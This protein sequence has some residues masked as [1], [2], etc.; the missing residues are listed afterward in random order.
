MPINYD[1]SV[2]GVNTPQ[3]ITGV[4]VDRPAAT[5]VAE[6]TI[7]ISTDTQEIY[8]AQ[9]GNWILISSIT[10]SAVGTLAQTLAAGN[11][12]NNQ[13]IYLN[14]IAETNY[15]FFDFINDVYRFYLESYG[16]NKGLR[17]VHQTD[18]NLSQETRTYTYDN[19]TF[20]DII[21]T[22]QNVDST[23]ASFSTAVTYPNTNINNTLYSSSNESR[24]SATYNQGTQAA[25]SNIQS[26]V[27]STRFESRFINDIINGEFSDLLINNTNQDISILTAYNLTNL[28]QYLIKLYNTETKN[29]TITHQFEL[30]VNQGVL[31]CV[32]EPIR[33]NNVNLSIGNFDADKY[34]IYVVTTGST[35]NKFRLANFVNNGQDGQFITLCVA[36]TRVD[37]TNTAGNIYGTANINSKGLY[38]LMK[39]GNDIYSS[40]I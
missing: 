24:V 16:G 38:K 31:A 2:T 32:N 13:T 25:S 3:A 40:H 12:A 22:S 6:G 34:G 15:V 9:A 39:I 36:D 11:Y 17:I 29:T 37:C 1:S 7:Y 20:N 4:I 18:T 14:N 27:L 28:T 33:N 30:P 19:T 21:Y 26:T 35:T 23:S 8:T 5:D 10:G